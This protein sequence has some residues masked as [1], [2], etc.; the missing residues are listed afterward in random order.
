MQ[1]V[2]DTQTQQPTVSPT[3]AQL[4][5]SLRDL[6]LHDFLRL[7]MT[8]YVAQYH[9]PDSFGAIIAKEA[10]HRLH[11]AADDA[12]Q[13]AELKHDYNQQTLWTQ[14]ITAFWRKAAIVATAVAVAAIAA[15]YR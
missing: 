2:T 5:A 12:L 3:A 7:Y 6:P 4:A 9:Q 13:L 15:L 11:W 10:V 1:F 14:R 8:P